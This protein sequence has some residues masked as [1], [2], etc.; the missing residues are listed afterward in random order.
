[1]TFIEENAET[2]ALERHEAGDETLIEEFVKAFLEDWQ[3]SIRKSVVTQETSRSL[4]PVPRGGGRSVVVGQKKPKP[5]L[6]D[7]KQFEDAAVQSFLDNGG[8]FGG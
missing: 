6:S 1:V 5:N 7:P 4:R 3:E 2:G 8:Q